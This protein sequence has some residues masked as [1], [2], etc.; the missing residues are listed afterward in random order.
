MPFVRIGYRRLYDAIACSLENLSDL[1]IEFPYAQSFN[2]KVYFGPDPRFGLALIKGDKYL[3]PGEL[4]MAAKI[5][6]SRHAK[7]TKYPRH[8]FCEIICWERAEVPQNLYDAFK[9]GDKEAK[10]A[11]LTL[12]KQRGKEF[13]RAADLIAGTIGL[14]F[15]RQFVKELIN[16]NYVAFDEDDYYAIDIYGKALELL[17]T[18]TLNSIGIEQIKAVLPQVASAKDQARDIG[19]TSLRWLM[20]A[21]G[22]R[23]YINRFIALFVPIEIIL[24]GQSFPQYEMRR[25]SREI[26]KLITCHGGEN[27]VTLIQ[28]LNSLVERQIPTL[29]ERFELFAKEANLSE[30]QHDFTAF[31]QFNSMRNLLLHRGGDDV[32]LSV[33][34]TEEVTKKLEEITIKYLKYW[35]LKN[36]S[37]SL[38]GIIK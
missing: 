33:K 31:K 30:W 8:F 32:R 24:T 25:Y 21:L 13:N 22:E 38:K 2:V 16:D 9:S 28:F 19:S 34:V 27:K 20:K 26:R 1:H 37:S 35:F 14:L 7:E 3:I 12:S 11:L 29:E 23:D 36:I 10:Q 5:D 17:H 6:Y 4:A 15:H 18:I